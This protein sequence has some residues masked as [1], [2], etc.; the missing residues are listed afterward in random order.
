MNAYRYSYGYYHTG[1]MGLTIEAENIKEAIEKILQNLEDRPNDNVFG[2][3]VIYF[4][5]DY[6]ESAKSSDKSDLLSGEENGS[7]E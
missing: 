4:S 1:L 2:G 5:I 3:P 6:V 7:S